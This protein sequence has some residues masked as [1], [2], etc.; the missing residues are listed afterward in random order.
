MGLGLARTADRFENDLATLKLTPGTLSASSSNFVRIMTVHASKG[1][2]FPHVAL[3]DLRLSGKAESL[4]AENIAASTYVA[5][6]SPVLRSV[7]KTIQ[8]LHE[9]I[10]QGDE[11]GADIMQASTYQDLMLSLKG[12]VATQEL[13]EARRLLYVALTRA[14]K[15]LFIGVAHSGNKNFSYEGKGILDDLHE[16]LQW[17]ASVNA[18]MQKLDYGGSAPMDFELTV[19]DTPAEQLE[20]VAEEEK[21]FTISGPLASCALLPAVSRFS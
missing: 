21:P 10:E 15:S 13:S 2:E 4:V 17:E 11:P 1:L 14:S 16:A 6:D 9:F 7:R 20:R 5:L 8:G 12:Y 19:L 18:P 3:A